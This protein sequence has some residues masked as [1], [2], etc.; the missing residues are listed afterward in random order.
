MSF[1]I[2]NLDLVIFKTAELLTWKIKNLQK[3]TK[4]KGLKVEV[5]NEITV[6]KPDVIYFYTWDEF[7][8]EVKFWS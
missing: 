6:L 7:T 2:P 5:Q 4:K 8:T 3:K 1:Q